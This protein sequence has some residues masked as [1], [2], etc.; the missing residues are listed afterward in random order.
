MHNKRH[1]LNSR[2]PPLYCCF[3]ENHVSQLE[4]QS[5]E[6]VVLH[7]LDPASLLIVFK[8]EGIHF[9]FSK[10][11]LDCISSSSKIQLRYNFKHFDLNYYGHGHILRLCLHLLRRNMEAFVSTNK[12]CH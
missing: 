8:L 7:F 3:F 12:G 11:T 2:R 9:F 4:E 6:D 1:V 10:G 5:I